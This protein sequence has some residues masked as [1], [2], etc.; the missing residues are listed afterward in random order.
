MTKKESQTYFFSAP[1]F[2]KKEYQIYFFG[3]P[4]YSKFDNLRKGMYRLWRDNCTCKFADKLSGVF[5]SIDAEIKTTDHFRND[6][7]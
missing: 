3:A 5:P 2:T 7:I 4:A 1:A 6:K